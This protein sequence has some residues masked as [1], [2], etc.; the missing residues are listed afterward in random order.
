MD[1]LV[2]TELRLADRRDLL[3][4]GLAALAARQQRIA[5]VDIGRDLSNPASVSFSR[6]G[7]TGSCVAPPTPRNSRM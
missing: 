4:H 5:A 2:E 3:A 7:F 6:N 1:V